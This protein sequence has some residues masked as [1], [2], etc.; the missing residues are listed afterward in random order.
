MVNEY[1]TDFTMT[2]LLIYNLIYG[3][4]NRSVDK[5]LTQSKIITKNYTP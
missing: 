5:K 2:L 1:R 3:C 4:G